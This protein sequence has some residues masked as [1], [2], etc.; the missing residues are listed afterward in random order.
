[1]KNQEDSSFPT[2]G[3]KA[4]LNKLNCK[5]V[6]DKQKADEHWQDRFVMILS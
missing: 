2:D 5:S 1:M 6:K 4:I 3:H